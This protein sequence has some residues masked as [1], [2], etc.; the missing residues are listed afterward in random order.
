MA[1]L[2]TTLIIL[3]IILIFP[4]SSML[5]LYKGYGDY[6]KVYKSLKNKTF[7]I[8]QDV[9]YSH[10]Y[11]EEDD[12]FVYFLN[13]KGFTLSKNTDLHNAYFTYFDPYS[14]YWY[15]KYRR[16]FNEIDITKLEK[17]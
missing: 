15:I 9:V 8:Y 3:Y 16:F 14:L 10:K 2:I 17:Y 5:T 13:E 4:I 6:S 7:Y 11:G 12:Y 1:T